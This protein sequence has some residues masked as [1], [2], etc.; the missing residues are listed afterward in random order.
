MILTRSSASKAKELVALR[1]TAVAKVNQKIGNTRL[2]FIT[3]LPGQEQTYGE[4]ERE[5]IHYVSTNPDPNFPG[6]IS[7][8]IYPF[9]YEE[10][11]SVGYT[12]WEAAQLFLNMAA[13]WR[14]LGAKLEGLRVGYNNL[15]GLEETAEGIEQNLADLTSILETYYGA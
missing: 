5:A 3:D 11:M 14:P 15:V 1:V 4:K 7:E 6:L 2:K 9:I 8:A 10:C 12:P 13:Q